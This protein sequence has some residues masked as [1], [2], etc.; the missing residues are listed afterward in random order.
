MHQ[1]RTQVRGLPAGSYVIQANYQGFAP[2]VSTPI[3]LTAGQTKNVDIKL[4]IE[5]ADVQVVV[6]D[7]G[8]P[9]VSTE[10]GANA[11]AIVLKGSDLDALSDDP[12]E[13][14]NELDGASRPFR[15]PERRPDLH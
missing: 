8:G 13:L 14:S 2:F 12:D 10:A 7:E 9:T 3:Q 5:A 6:T 1:A 11:N 4:A 15:G